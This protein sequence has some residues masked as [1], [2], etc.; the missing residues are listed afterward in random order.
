MGREFCL[1]GRDVHRVDCVSNKA[2]I[3]SD[4]VGV[5]NLVVCER[6]SIIVK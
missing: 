3:V 4:H 5:T 2:N 6:I 1:V